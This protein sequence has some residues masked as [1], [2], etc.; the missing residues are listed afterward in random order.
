MRKERRERQRGKKQFSSH[1]SLSKAGKTISKNKPFVVWRLGIDGKKVLSKSR[2]SSSGKTKGGLPFRGR[3]SK[4]PRVSNRRAYE[5]SLKEQ[6][7]KR[8]RR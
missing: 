4:I 1:G 6:K 7:K 2:R 8:R 3:K 5:K